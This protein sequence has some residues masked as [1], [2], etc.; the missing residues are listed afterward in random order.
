MNT[1]CLHG[2]DGAGGLE[3]VQELE[4]GYGVRVANN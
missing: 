1:L 2:A 3:E 4:E